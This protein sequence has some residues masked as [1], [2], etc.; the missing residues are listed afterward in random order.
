Y[1]PYLYPDPQP[2]GTQTPPP[3]PTPQPTT[4]PVPQPSDCEQKLAKVKEITWSRRRTA[5][6]ELRAL[7][8]Q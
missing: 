5:L 8:P 1:R 6:R 4:Q 2:S 7:I 3:T